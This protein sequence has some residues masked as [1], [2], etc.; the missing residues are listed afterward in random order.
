MKE[1]TV[2]R[3]VRVVLVDERDR[4]LL[5]RTENRDTRKQFW[6]PPGGGIE[7]GETAEEAAE[8]E[9]FEETGLHS[10]RLDV[11][12]W[13]RRHVF[14]WNTD[15]WDQQERW[16]LARTN[17]FAP[18]MAGLGDTEMAEILEW[19]WWTTAGLRSSGE[20]FV[21]LNFPELFEALMRD[22]PPDLPSEIGE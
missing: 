9:L 14:M 5:F 22:G 17:H 1:P 10:L 18:N 21:P 2:R 20:T 16:F 3:A 8:R 19:R 12:I 4:V 15:V 11:E 6:F 13:W 7:M